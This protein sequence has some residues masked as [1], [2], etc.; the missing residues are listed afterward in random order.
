MNI[1]TKLLLLLAMVAT[2]PLAVT[3]IVLL[4]QSAELE[5][6]LVSASAEAG[7]QSAQTSADALTAQAKNARRTI[8]NEKASQLKAYFDD[9][10]RAVLV[11]KVTHNEGSS[12]TR[13]IGEWVKTHGARLTQALVTEL[14]HELNARTKEIEDLRKQLAKAS[15]LKVG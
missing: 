1:F 3:T 14:Q 8:V 10:R 5:Q 4:V 13:A 2:V 12:A 15:R 6:E 11:R 9:I 7:E